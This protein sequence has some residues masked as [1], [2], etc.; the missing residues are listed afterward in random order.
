MDGMKRDAIDQKE[1]NQFAI[2]Y[3]FNVDEKS[4][5]RTDLKLLFIVTRMVQK[6]R[7]WIHGKYDKS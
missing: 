5:I 4:K 1:S 3:I 6:I 7:L 2:K